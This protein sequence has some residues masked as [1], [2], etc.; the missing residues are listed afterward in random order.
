[1]GGGYWDSFGAWALPIQDTSCRTEL[2]LQDLKDHESGRTGVQDQG[3]GMGG[4]S[5]D[6]FGF[7][8]QYDNERGLRDDAHG[9]PK[10]AEDPDGQETE[11]GNAGQ[12]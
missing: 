2:Q 7:K 12:V 6:G 11:D 9:S 4:Y 5:D 1:M 3:F 10:A 8:R